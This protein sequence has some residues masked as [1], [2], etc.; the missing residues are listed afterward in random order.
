[1]LRVL[2]VVAAV[3][4]IGAIATRTSSGN[5]FGGRANSCRAATTKG[6]VRAFVADYNKGRVTAMNKMWAPEPYFQW[7]FA[8]APGRRLGAQAY[9]RTT[10][11]AYFRGRVRVHERLVL[12]HL[13]AG[14]DPIRN[15]VNFS[16][17][18][19]RS[20]DDIHSTSRRPFKGAADCRADGPSLIVWSM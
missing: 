18:L 8:R 16:G 17:D 13:V 14:Y 10:L 6:L 2:W 1:M 12:T 19:L 7:F 20:A 4:L 9:D 11:G 5:A 3:V 15:I